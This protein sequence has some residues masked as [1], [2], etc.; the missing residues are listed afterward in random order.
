MQQYPKWHPLS[1]ELTIPYL[2]SK[3]V[4]YCIYSSESNFRQVNSC[5]EH[6]PCGGKRSSNK[7]SHYE[8]LDF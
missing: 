7:Q 3:R 5:N 2:K 8:P 1:R 4:S 6:Q